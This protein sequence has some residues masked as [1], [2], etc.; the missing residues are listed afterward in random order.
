MQSGAWAIM[1][2]FWRINLLLFSI[3]MYAH[4]SVC[5]CSQSMRPIS[6]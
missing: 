3:D 1:S 6:T 2:A 5:V 4:V